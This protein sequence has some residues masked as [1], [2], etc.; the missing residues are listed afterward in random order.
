MKSVIEIL[1]GVMLEQSALNSCKASE[2]K[3]EEYALYEDLRKTLTEEQ[4]EN[5]ERFIYLYGNRL[6]KEAEKTYRLGFKK[7]A[8]L[9]I[10]VL[11]PD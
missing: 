1:Y 11:T 4:T 2:N 7:G 3:D 10:E 9:N 8:L 5:F 6:C